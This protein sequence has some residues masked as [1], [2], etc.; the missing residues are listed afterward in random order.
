MEQHFYQLKNEIQ[1][2]ID[3]FSEEIRMFDSTNT[4]TE[5][6]N[7]QIDQKTLKFENLFRIRKQNCILDFKTTTS[8]NPES[9][10]Y[11]ENLEKLEKLITTEKLDYTICLKT[12]SKEIYN[13]NK[14]RE[15]FTNFKKSITSNVANY[16]TIEPQ[17]QDEEFERLWKNAFQENDLDELYREQ[18][19]TDFYLMFSTQWDLIPLKKVVKLYH[20][21]NYSFDD[22]DTTLLK[23]L[24]LNL[25][26]CAPIKKPFFYPTKKGAF[27][28]DLQ[29]HCYHSTRLEYLNENTFYY[30][31][32]TEG[33]ESKFLKYFPNSK[34]IY[35][36]SFLSIFLTAKQYTNMIGYQKIV[37]SYNHPK[38]SRC[39]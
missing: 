32:T 23:K 39:S 15:L 17:E 24:E 36:L 3:E 25:T 31:H 27:L 19:L 22:V 13:H 30:V 16:L 26:S 20:K 33:Q 9:Q 8:A 2:T 28:K 10:I 4:S 6:L 35:K 29:P 1:A 12:R 14:R 37:Y 7:E 18:N 34:T 11:I 5:Q 38:D 21:L